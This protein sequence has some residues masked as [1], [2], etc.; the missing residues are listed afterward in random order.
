MQFPN[1]TPPYL[2]ADVAIPVAQYLTDKYGKTG[3]KLQSELD[4]DLNWR[5]TIQLKTSR[6]TTM[7]VEV[8]EILYPQLL[9]GV[10]HDLVADFSD[11]P[12]VVC[13]ACPLAV[14]QAD[15]RQAVVSK[16]KSHGFGIITADD[17]GN[18][19]EQVKAIPLIHHISEADFLA[20]IHDLNPT[21]RVQ[22]RQAYDTYRVN[23]YQGLQDV[24]Q[25]IEGLIFGFAKGA[26]KKGW[27][28]SVKSDAAF[29]LDDLFASS[30]NKLQSQRAVIGGARSFVKFYRNMSSHPP[31]TTKDAAKLVKECRGGFFQA[32]QVADQLSTAMR[33]CQLTIRLHL[34]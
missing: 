29:V 4:S 13:V 30:N 19:I 28:A 7:G 21:V 25:V 12:V 2:E 1:L 24:A 14:Y 16:L 34:P 20:K 27:I 18:V 32:L 26:R 11:T 3:F 23:S 9:K 31:K 17:Q 6:F 33:N 10:S 5:P 8:S 15:S 22:A